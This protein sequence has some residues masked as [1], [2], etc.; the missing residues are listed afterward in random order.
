MGI[1]RGGYLSGCGMVDVLKMQGVGAE[2]VIVEVRI[3]SPLR[4]R[5]NTH[6]MRAA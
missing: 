3:F 5:S 1:G 2:Q 4:V 6:S